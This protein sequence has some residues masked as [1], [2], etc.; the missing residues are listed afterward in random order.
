[1]TYTV[2]KDGRP[3]RKCADLI[4]AREII[5]ENGGDGWGAIIGKDDGTW[6]ITQDIL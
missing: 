6:T 3:F 5:N 1:M 4:E 2:H